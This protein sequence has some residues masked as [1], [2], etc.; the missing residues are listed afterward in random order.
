MLQAWREAPEGTSRQVSVQASS[1]GREELQLGSS[2]V[3]GKSQ[4]SPEAGHL[5]VAETE[6][7][8]VS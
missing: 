8:A 3:P 1:W 2:L 5:G 7:Q 6:S 4:H